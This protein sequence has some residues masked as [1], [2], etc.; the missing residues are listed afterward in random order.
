MNLL[1]SICIAPLVFVIE[2]VFMFLNDRLG[3]AGFA[4]IGVSLFVGLISTPLYQRAE[5]IQQAEREKQKEMEPCIAHIRKTFQGDTRFMTLQTYYRQNHYK[6]WYVLRSSFSLLLQVPFFIA[7]WS[8]IS[9]L[10]LLQGRSFYTLRIEDLSRPDTLL[11]VGDM[12]LP[13]LPIVMTILNVLSAIVYTR[14][15]LPREKI[16]A[17]LLPLFFLVLL[18]YSPS[19]LVLYWTCNQ[20]FSLLRNIIAARKKRH[21]KT[22]QNRGERTEHSVHSAVETKVFFLSAALMGILTGLLIPVSLI[23]VSPMEFVS[24]KLQENPLWFALAAFGIATGFFCLWGGVY[25]FMAK[26]RT[27]R[28]MSVTVFLLSAVFLVIYFVFGSGK[29]EISAA[30][31]Y[32]NTPSFTPRQVLMNL[33]LLLAVIGALLFL[34]KKKQNLCGYLLVI[35]NLVL[36]TLT[37]IGAFRIQSA[38]KE[39]SLLPSQDAQQTDSGEIAPVMHFSRGGKNVVVIMLDRAV[40]AFIPFIMQE[41]PELARQFEGFTFYPNT[42]SHGVCT[43]Y[44]APGLFGGYEYTVEAMNLRSDVPL[45]E[46]HHEALKLMPTIFSENG[47]RVTVIDPPFV[48]YSYMYDVSIYDDMPG[49]EA[50]LLTGR[51][52][53]EMSDGSFTE[54]RREN[55]NR[56]MFAYGLFQTAPLVL[57]PVIYDEGRYYSSYEEPAGLE[58]FLE[59]YTVLKHLLPLTECTDSETDSF[60]MM[61]NSTTHENIELQLPEY[62]PSMHIDNT[63]MEQTERTLPDGSSMGMGSPQAR[64]QYHV[65]VAAFCRLGEWLDYLREQGVYDNTRI[66]VTSD[67]GI[68]MQH[69]REMIIPDKLDVEGVNPVLLVKDFGQTGALRTDTT[70]MTNADTPFLATKDVIRNPVNPFTGRALT[71]DWKTDNGQLVTTSYHHNPWD[72][73]GMV[74]DL[75]DGDAFRVRDNIFDHE[76]WIPV[77]SD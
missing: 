39:V 21:G 55:R 30:L 77:T 46:K 17:F 15:A 13:L 1:Y 68:A 12:T 28:V 6:P 40:G 57:Q 26:E 18:F 19:G 71:D 76:N 10:Q 4:L 36:L 42:L 56:N 16:Q 38:M 74:F 35:L 31:V 58:S 54:G 52:P 53:D 73:D 66:I 9:N 11:S 33:L 34:W 59:N 60:I 50:H 63:G 70:F 47:Y 7:A 75:S 27:R 49:V 48:N 41:K 44:G 43:L 64:G 69:F 5:A 37:G 23:A 29:G 20:V 3:S 67:H 25:F 24:V 62:E 32:D 22:E 61:Q 65:T 45:M 51:L 14:G 72:H 8:F 2:I